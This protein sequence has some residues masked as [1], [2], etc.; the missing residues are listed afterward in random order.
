MDWV[1]RMGRRVK[2][3]DLHVLLAVAESGSMVKAAKRLAVSHPVVSKTISEL[4]ETLGVRLFDR[5]AQGV[6]ATSYGHVLLRL[7]LVVFDE[8]RQGLKE[9]EFI[10]NPS[11]GEVRLGCPEIT[12]AGLL[13]DI[14]QTFSS[15]YP[16]VNLHI[17]LA[18]TGSMQFKELRERSLDLVI[19]RLPKQFS[20]DDL[21]AEVLFDEPFLAVAGIGSAWA[22]KRRLA[23]ADLMHE[24]WVLPA[25]DSAPGQLILE[26]FRQS[27]LQPVRPSVTTMSGQLTVTLIASGR[28]VG[29]LPQSVARL[30]AER[31]ALKVLPIAL[32]SVRIASGIVTVKGR[33]LSPLV[34]RF[35]D[36]ARELAKGV[37]T[38]PLAVAKR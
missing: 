2:L 14:A 10:A 36:C 19:G 1:E 21:E 24:P 13:P 34:R 38:A 9:L 28:F 20:E 27:Q 26:M 3:R 12:M 15:R 25:Y 31:A 35:I 23:L 4:E 8:V 17:A 30:S 6:E 29:V 5:H 37:P 33:T 7:G 16:G 11:A 18:N 32:P 22:R